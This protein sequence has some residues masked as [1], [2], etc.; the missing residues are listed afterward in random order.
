[1]STNLHTARAEHGQGIQPIRVTSF[2][3]GNMGQMLQLHTG[4]YGGE[5]DT[6]QATEKQVRELHRTMGEWLANR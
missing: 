3:G 1:M 4:G 2:S 5:E 6:I